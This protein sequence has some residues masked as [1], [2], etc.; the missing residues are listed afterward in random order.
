MEQFRWEDIALH[1]QRESCWI[2]IESFVYDVTDF[3]SKVRPQMN[4]NFFNRNNI[5]F[6]FKSYIKNNNENVQ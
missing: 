2:V 5:L 6:I 3:L 4:I 1:N